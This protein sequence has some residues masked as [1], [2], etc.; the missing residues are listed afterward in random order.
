ML[1]DVGQAWCDTVGQ[2]WRVTSYSGS[3]VDVVLVQDAGWVQSMH[4][5][6]FRHWRR[7]PGMDAA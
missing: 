2:V 7:M 1:V 4:V 5:S 6:Q 3:R